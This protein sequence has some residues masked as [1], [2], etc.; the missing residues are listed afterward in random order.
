[1]DIILLIITTVGPIAMSYISYRHPNTETPF[2]R[3]SWPAFWWIIL[4]ILVISS[5]IFVTQRN[6]NQSNQIVNLSRL[7]RDTAISTNKVSKQLAKKLDT[8][9]FKFDS[10]TGLIIPLDSFARQ[11]RET[12]QLLHSIDSTVRKTDN[13]DM[14][15]TISLDRDGHEILITEMLRSRYRVATNFVNVG[16]LPIEKADPEILLFDLKN[17]K[18][19]GG[20]WTSQSSENDAIYYSGQ[21][22]TWTFNVNEVAK[23][24]IGD[25]VYIYYNAKYYSGKDRSNPR[26]FEC[27][28][29]F[30]KWP[31]MSLAFEPGHDEVKKIKNLIIQFNSTILTKDQRLNQKRPIN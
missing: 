7:I 12:R 6:S 31:D 27:L 11:Y 1:M 22:W 20:D 4:A 14:K 23:S 5:G 3:L 9:G 16:D 25:T 8:L 26:L 21:H 15:G 28:I 24:F 10:A 2:S 17:A 13:H 18:Y 19:T 29:R 30:D